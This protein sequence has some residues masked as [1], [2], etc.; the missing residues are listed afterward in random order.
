MTPRGA[1]A[2]LACCISLA[3]TAPTRRAMAQGTT[4]LAASARQAGSDTTEVRAVSGARSAAD[5]SVAPLDRRVS[6]ALTGVTLRDALQEIVSQSG[7]NL[8]YSSRVVPVERRVSARLTR[9][10]VRAALEKVLAGTGVEVRE[11]GARIILA[12]RHEVK[13]SDASEADTIR[14]TVIVRVV[15][16][17]T[18]KPIEGATVAVRGTSLTTTTSNAGYGALWDVPSGLQVVTVRFLG[19]A[20]AEEQIVVPRSGD[21]RITIPIRMGMTRLQ[22]VVTTATGQHRRYELGN[23]I[24]ILDV[25]SI[26]ATQPITSVT[27][28]LEGRVP[29]LTIQHTSGAPGDPSRLRLRGASS[30]LRSNDPI[31]IVDGIRVYAAQ[32]DSSSTN[33]GNNPYSGYFSGGGTHPIA[34]PSPLDQIDPN[35]IAT[36]AVMK[37][38]SAATMYGPDAANGVI[39]ITTKRGGAGPARWTL[40]ASRGMSYM[41]G[42]YPAGLYR[43]G[44][45]Y[46]GNTKLCPIADFG[47]QADSLVR[48]QALNDDRYSLLGHGQNTK[49]SLGVSG[50]TAAL[51]YALTGSYGNETGLPRLPD[52][53]AER[54]GT[55]HGGAAPPDWMRRPQKLTSWSGSSRLTAKLG[56]HADASLSTMLTRQTQRRSSLEQQIATLMTTYVDPATDTYWRAAGPMFFFR[57]DELIPDFF[58]RATS[59]STNFTNAANITWRPLNWLTTSAD[60]GINAISRQDELLLPR[61]MLSFTDS[62]GRLNMGHGND[63]V[64]TVNLRATAT[65]PLPLGFRLQLATGANY[66]RTSSGALSTG[67]SDLADGTSSL[68]G[69]GEITYASQYASDVTSFGWY[70]EPSFTHRKF[71]IST[72]LRLDGSSS[73]GSNVKL[74]AFPKLGVSWLVSEEPFFPFKNFFDVFRVRAAYGRAGVWPGEADRLRLYKTVRPWLGGGFQDALQVSTIGNSEL[75]PERSTEMEGGFDADLLGDRLSVGVT[76]YRKMRHDALISTPVAPSV[77]GHSVTMLRNVGVIRNTGV[78][79]TMSAQLVRSDPVSWSTTFNLSRNHNEVKELGAGVQPFGVPDSRVV[80]GYPL[81]GRWARPILGY[82]DVNGNKVIERSEVQLGDSLVFMGASEPNYEV[83]MFTTF[84]FFRGA[85]TATAGFAYQDGLTQKN[86]AIVGTGQAIFS[87]GVSDPSS[88]FGE[89]AAVAVMGETSYGLLQTV[90]TLRLNSVSLAFNAPPSLARR[91][92]TKALTIAVQGTNVGLWTN[93]AGKDPNVNAFVTGNSVADTGVLPIPRSWLLSVRATY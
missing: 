37:G 2:L 70:I 85:L 59:S 49:L 31:V 15:D 88:S 63:V 86:Q 66:T 4:T 40:S 56:E 29:G 52:V 44:H 64:S 32:S 19:Y 22:D 76:G 82:S 75:R 11:E 43:W 87:P 34:T 47:C 16:T 33:L 10:T 55:L 84:S 20:P 25:D 42:E 5:T 6:L 24:T 65:A 93:Y 39:V 35:S 54:F 23:D 68:N 67:V 57:V 92:G 12:R 58:Q 7:I 72:G 14:A 69:A 50:G 46:S 91:L 78:E 26:V 48:F 27:D 83:N 79:L 90:S 8:S 9:V 17:S 30:V 3:W 13:T 18:A 73:F 71:T 28:L 62:T 36:I 80:E 89:Q 60:A 21:V 1:A 81:F 41:P 61:G 45:D 53:E 77:Y 74:P 51:T 38:P